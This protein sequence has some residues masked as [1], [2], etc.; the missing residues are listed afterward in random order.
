MWGS[1]LLLWFYSD[2]LSCVSIHEWHQSSQNYLLTMGSENCRVITWRGSFAANNI[3]YSPIMTLHFLLFLSPL[4]A[5]PSLCKAA[6]LMIAALFFQNYNKNQWWRKQGFIEGH[7]LFNMIKW[8]FRPPADLCVTPIRT[9]VLVQQFLLIIQEHIHFRESSKFCITKTGI[10][11]QL[12]SQKWAGDLDF[13]WLVW[14]RCVLNDEG[15]SCEL[16]VLVR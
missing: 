15:L 4:F 10:N 16:N 2:L 11:S 8:C 5:S 3:L 13:Y 7:M 14:C 9:S 1:R 12:F 6:S